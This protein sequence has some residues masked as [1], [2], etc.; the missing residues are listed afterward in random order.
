MIL[1]YPHFRKPPSPTVVAASWEEGTIVGQVIQKGVDFFIAMFA[2]QSHML[3]RCIHGC[4][5]D[6]QIETEHWRL[7]ENMLYLC[8]AENE[9]R[10]ENYRRRTMVKLQNPHHHHHKHIM[11]IM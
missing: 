2:Y 4:L 7:I 11:A 5:N 6:S 1:W 3:F 8:I 9:S 10:N